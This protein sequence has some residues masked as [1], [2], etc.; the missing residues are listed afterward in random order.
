MV[1]VIVDTLHLHQHQQG[2]RYLTDEVIHAIQAQAQTITIEPSTSTTTPLAPAPS[3]STLLA[4]ST[5]HKTST[6]TTTPNPNPNPQHG[7]PP[8]PTPR[9][10]RHNRVLAPNSRPSTSHSLQPPHRNRRRRQPTSPSFQRPHS[11]G[12]RRGFHHGLHP[13]CL[14]HDFNPG[15]QRE[16]KAV[17]GTG[18]GW[19][20]TEL[21]GGESEAAWG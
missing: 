9:S 6:T 10:S 12:S 13:V 7:R 11:N 18:Y 21:V 4:Q 20:G 16:C 17:Q 8:L 1:S 14:Q 3:H 15:R 2:S 19:G 5:L